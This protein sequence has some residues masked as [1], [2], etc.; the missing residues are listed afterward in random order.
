MAA[1]LAEWTE[2]RYQCCYEQAAKTDTATVLPPRFDLLPMRKYRYGSVQAS[3]GCLFTCEFCDII[4]VFARRRR[5]K[6]AAQVI[7]EL[8]Q[9]VAAGKHD[10][11]IADDNLIGNREASPRE[12]KKIQNLPDRAGTLLETLHRI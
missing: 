1:L 9:L 7:V 11:F 2:S 8:D 5:I 4:V 3:R 12:T 10:V 6:T